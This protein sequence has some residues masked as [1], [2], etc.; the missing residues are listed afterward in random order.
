MDTKDCPAF[1]TGPPSLFVLNE[2]PYAELPYV[3]E[4]L[5]HTH[6][7]R[8]S[9]PLIQVIQIGTRKAVTTETVPDS[10]LYD[11]LTVLDSARDAGFR[12]D[13]VVAPATGTCILLSLIRHAEATVHSAGSDQRR[14]NLVCLC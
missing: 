9:I 12:F 7:I 13:A 10:S 4:I 14:A 3:L 11:V 8:G 5:N 6:A 1:G 2:M